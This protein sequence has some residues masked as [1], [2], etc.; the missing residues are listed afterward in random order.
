MCDKIFEYE[1]VEKWYFW[2]SSQSGNTQTKTHTENL[3]ILQIVEYSDELLN[4]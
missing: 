4:E 2:M 3:G 1:D